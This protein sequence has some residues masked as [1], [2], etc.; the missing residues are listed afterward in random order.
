MPHGNQGEK[1][2]CRMQEYS[3]QLVAG[4]ASGGLPCV[5]KPPNHPIGDWGL[6]LK[7]RLR[8]STNLVNEV[9]RPGRKRPGFSFALGP[10][11]CPASC[12]RSLYSGDFMLA[13]L[14]H[15]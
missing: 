14:Q 6:R 13:G 3:P 4:T 10:L 8:S 5:D 11:G 2:C 12:N 1:P 7:W 9:L 15:P